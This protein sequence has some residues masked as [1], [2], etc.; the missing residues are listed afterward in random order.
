MPSSNGKR[1]SSDVPTQHLSDG[2]AKHG[3]PSDADRW[4]ESAVPPTLEE[5]VESGRAHFVAW[6]RWYQAMYP[7]ASTNEALA[8]L[9]RV[10]RAAVSMLL[11]PGAKRTPDFETLAS[12]RKLLNIPYDS[13]LRSDPPPLPPGREGSKTSRSG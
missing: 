8:K 9:L 10:S 4:Y 11:K 5:E 2:G 3:D 12:V 13:L 1:N 7:A 6:L